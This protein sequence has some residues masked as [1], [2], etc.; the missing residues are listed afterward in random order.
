MLQIHLFGTPTAFCKDEPLQ[1]QHRASRALLF[2]LAAQNHPVSRSALAG[3]FWPD[4]D[5]QKARATLRDYLHKLRHNLCDNQ[6][7]LTQQET[8]GLDPARIQV[9]YRDFQAQTAEIFPQIS[10]LSAEA[11]LPA[12]LYQQLTRVVNLR[13]EYGFL[14]GNDMDFSNEL[15]AWR[16]NRAQEVETQLLLALERLSNHERLMQRYDLAIHWLTLGLRIDRYNTSFNEE[17]LKT[18]LQSDLPT[19]AR[20]HFTSLR[21]AFRKDFDDELPPEILALEAPIFHPEI[22]STADNSTWPVRPTMQVPFTGQTDLLSVFQRVTRRGGALM[23]FGEAGA[24]KTRLAREAYQ[25]QA[26]ASRLLLA[27]CQPMET[28]LPFAPWVAMLRA[29]VRPEEWKRLDSVWARPLTLLLPEIANFRP[30]LSPLPPQNPEIPLLTLLEAIRQVLILLSAARPLFLFLDDA[31]WADES[32][33]EEIAYLLKNKFFDLRRGVLVLA[34]RLEARN[35]LLDQLLLTTFP[36]TVTRLE[37]RPL[38]TQQVAELCQLVLGV[39][40]PAKM[41]Q[42]LEQDLSGNPLFLLET[43]QIFRETYVNAGA[44]SPYDFPLPHSVLE[45]LNQRVDA[46]SISARELL[47][48]AAVMGSRVE[49]HLAQQVT[50][51]DGVE[52]VRAVEEL[53]HARLLEPVSGEMLL[54]AFPHEKIREALLTNISPARERLL[55]QKIAETLQ[56]TLPQA[57]SARLAYHFEKAGNFLRA[58]DSWISAGHYAYRLNAIGETI[59][60]YRHAEHLLSLST[61]F[62]DEQLYRLYTDWNKVVFEMDDAVEI[63]RI[64]HSFLNLGR[65]HNSS[66]LIGAALS[67]L[68]NAG[69]ARNE[70]AD[71]LKN[72]RLAH[73]YV[74]YS[75][76]LYE[77]TT[78]YNRT[79][80]LLYMLGDLRGSQEWFARTLALTETAM[81][82]DLLLARASAHYQ[83]AITETLCGYPISGEQHAQESLRLHHEQADTYG[84]IG[85]YSVISLACYLM[86]QYQQG[87][88]AALEGIAQAKRIS[89]WRMDGYINC[90][91]GLNE[92]EMGL[93]GAAWQHGQRAIEIGRKQGHGEITGLGCKVIGDIYA[94]LKNYKKAAEM[95]QQGMVTAGEHFVALENMHCYGF[96]LYQQGQ[97][98]VGKDFLRTALEKSEQAQLWSINFLAVLHELTILAEEGPQETFYQRA[99]WFS[100]EI[101]I[102]LKQD[103][104]QFTL[105]R[106][107]AGIALR[108]GECHRAVQLLD[109]P[110]TWYRQIGQSWNE[111]NGLKLQARALDDMKEDP[112]AQCLR[113]HELLM[114]LQENL[115]PAPLEDEMDSFWIKFLSE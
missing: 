108:N 102:R 35:H 75:E 73:A 109:R 46:L 115:S 26:S 55:H 70:F 104:G 50:G 18:F 1:I 105:A 40:A 63:E 42:R 87:R 22:A 98:A 95:Y 12:P 113:M 14:Q 57:Q 17:I 4:F 41:A 45:V 25:R 8:I 110:L 99:K 76:N 13:Q 101:S 6:F 51:V 74:E 29:C 83:M 2:Y 71:G 36:Q 21:A 107:E 58:F 81:D 54:Y 37:M 30:G 9:D 23:L 66:L 61:H 78:L 39:P 64:N 67:S 111:L 38:N 59:S 92:V 49:I 15:A 31:Q 96:A 34:S 112:S 19:R 56:F 52:G 100:H 60:A 79:G 28:S 43:L 44:V 7:I 62:S 97:H 32:T 114:F 84:E 68:S 80:V 16:E 90:Y 77:I 86:G 103:I 11:S 89:G 94:H 72:V 47:Q 33:L 91:A 88:Q 20:E 48:C 106:L 53:Q 82:R 27:P 65:E 3:L 5:E 69:M 93:L 10:R 85:A 24:G